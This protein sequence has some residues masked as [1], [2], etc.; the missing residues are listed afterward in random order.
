MAIRI[1]FLESAMRQNFFLQ[2]SFY[3]VGLAMAGS[4]L[5][6][7]AQAQDSFP[8]QPL[9]IVV[10]FAAGGGNDILARLLAKELT[11]SLG[12]AVMVENRPGAGGHIAAD[13]VA[14]AAPTG[15]TLL[16]GSTGA[17][18]ILP[19]MVAK[20]SFDPRKDLSP[21][22]LVAESGNVV[23]VNNKVAARNVSELV[24]LAKKQ[25][26]VLNYGSSGNGSTL[27][28]AGALFTHQA[29]IDMM[30]VPYKGNS[31]AINDVSG[32]QIQVVFSGIP[33][34]LSSAKTGQ[35]RILAVTTKERV[36][37]LPEVPTVAEAGIPGYEFSSWYGL[38]TTGGTSPQVIDRLGQ[39]VRKALAKPELI[40]SFRAQGVE[41][42]SN[43]P[44]EFTVQVDRELKQWSR[45]IK[46]LGITID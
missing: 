7:A 41:P 44:Q 26:G 46:A 4:L 45:D 1:Y 22:S 17:Q 18:T 16:L 42:I 29:G 20:M 28:L 13:L 23:L 9:R 5:A 15:H 31:Q 24:A 36:K 6:G 12:V 3:L 39:E 8:N 32:G 43:T 35:T 25:P 11:Q 27:H 21:V 30:H 37:S 19:A 34:A 2:K 14:K 10:G 38:F 33:P 40:A